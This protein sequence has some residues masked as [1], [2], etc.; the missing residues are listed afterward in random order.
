MV[1]TGH[2]GLDRLEWRSDVPCPRPD[3]GEVLIRVGAC[4]LN[5]TDINTRTAWYA[6]EVQ[7]GITQDT[8]AVGFRPEDEAGGTWGD[9]PMR[10][11]RIQGADVAG[12][13]VAVGAGVAAERVGERVLCDPWLLA[14]GDYLDAARSSY[15]GSEVDGGFA[16]FM[17][18][19]AEN[20]H[21]IETE[22]S[23]AELAAFPCAISTAENLVQRTNLLPGERVV[24][25]GASGG[26]GSMAVQLSKLRGAHVTALAAPSKFDQV[27]A[28][29]ADVLIDRSAP[30]LAAQIGSVDVA[31]DV[32]GQ[33]AF[34][35]LIQA[36]RHG[37]RYSSC[38]AIAGAQV[39]FDLRELI[40]RDLQM[41][42]ATIVPPGTFARLVKLIEAGHIQ[43]Q[44][45]QTFA[46]EDLHAA[47]EAFLAKNHTGNIVVICG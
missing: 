19:R 2:G 31:L 32:V 45:A 6:P 30:D 5:N 14:P 12:H 36:L 38:G 17:A 29:G 43:P 41:T 20:A 22:L 27:R 39:D 25:A 16:E 26:V 9:T 46:L 34:A 47:Q 37:G 13:I 35:S 24:I 4:G 18:I 1:L 42:G 28:L 15:L 3:R 23:D 11:P 33:G 21:A 8:G 44:L 7:G 10:F 40:Y